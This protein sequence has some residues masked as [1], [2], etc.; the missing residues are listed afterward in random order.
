MSESAPLSDAETIARLVHAYTDL[1]AKGDLDGIANLFIHGAVSGDAHP[2]PAVGRA[3]VLELYRATLASSAGGPRRLR[4]ATTDLQMQIND[5]AGT[6]ACV[7]R[8]TVRPSDAGDTDTVLFE[9][10]YLDEFARFDGEWAFTRRHVA[11][12]M[13]NR[14]AVDREGVHLGD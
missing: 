10:R 9:G 3:A 13:T 11:L 7:S 1:V 5:T 6:A 2:V 4:V 12:D 14:E 8:F